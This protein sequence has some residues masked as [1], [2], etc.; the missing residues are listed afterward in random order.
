MATQ[1][2]TVV[3]DRRP[4]DDE[5]NALFEA[6][7]DDVAF[8]VAGGLPVAEF[9]RAAPTMVD[10]IVS[11]VRALES[12]G[13]AAI[14]IIDQ[15]LVTL[16]DIADRIGQSRES[17]RRYA[18]G[19]RGAGDFPPPANPVRDGTVFYRW[20]EVAPWLRDHLHI[21]VTETDQA[22]VA[23]NLVVQARQLRHRVTDM[24]ALSELLT[25]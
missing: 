1:L 12:V 19:M 9:D 8:G 25:A 18:T 20:S 15:D 21:D 23:A 17:V 11:A 22:L 6:G 16:A 4:T 10:A 24:S 2:F 14:R 7:C 13:L 5:L 3:L